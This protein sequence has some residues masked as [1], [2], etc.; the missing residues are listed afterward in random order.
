[1]RLLNYFPAVLTG[2]QADTAASQ[3]WHI[4]NRAPSQPLTHEANSLARGNPKLATAEFKGS[5]ATPT[6]I[7][8]IPLKECCAMRPSPVVLRQIATI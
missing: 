7:P 3:M 2:E 5:L 1:M 8:N 6:G 4:G